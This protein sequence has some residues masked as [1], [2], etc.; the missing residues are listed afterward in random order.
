MVRIGKFGK[1]S[2]LRRRLLVCLLV[3]A[4]LAPDPASPGVLMAFLPGPRPAKPAPVS[5]PA[6]DLVQTRFVQVAPRF[7]PE[8][9]WQ[10]T[11][12]RQVAVVLLH[13]F[14]VFPFHRDYAVRA[15]FHSWQKP[16]SKLVEA[17]A[18]F[19]DVFAFAYSQNVA[20]DEIAAVPDLAAGVHWLKAFGYT[21]I[22]LIGHSA[23]GLIARQFVEDHPAAGVTKVIQVCA[24]NTG[25]NY[26]QLGPGVQKT[27]KPFVRSLTKEARARTVQSRGSK[28]IP[29]GLQFVCV[30]GDGVGL[31]DGVVANGSQWPA[32]LQRQGVP[33]VLLRT[34]HFTV[35][36]S[37]AEIQRLTELVRTHI[38]R[39]A[40]G[41][42]AVAKKE[43]HLK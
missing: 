39:W 38:P 13:G 20:V 3:L 4:P 30:V 26:A 15:T 27:Q 8:G 41:Q 7:N 12:S 25:T 11:R 23:G 19:A 28:P 32:D 16:G 21:E 14:H 37:P 17:L 43:L 31:G 33:A 24:P 34:T 18:P 6:L 1:A 9:A 29:A 22:V 36:R 10:R 35:V 2:N 5:L 40:P 42:V